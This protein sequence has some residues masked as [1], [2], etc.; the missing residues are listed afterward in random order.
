MSCEFVNE[1]LANYLGDE[2][3]DKDRTRIVGHLRDCPRC[4][5]EV[6]GLTATV[7]RLREVP[8]VPTHAPVHHPAKQSWRQAFAY[9]AVLMIGL[10]IGWTIKPASDGSGSVNGVD[11]MIPAER[12]DDDSQVDGSML[13]FRERFPKSPFA[14]NAY[15]MMRALS[16]AGVE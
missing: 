3:S 16:S 1:N 6:D 9:A 14:R 4:R 12:N 15:R 8:S 5:A 10:G 2:L 11:V 7:D 13:V